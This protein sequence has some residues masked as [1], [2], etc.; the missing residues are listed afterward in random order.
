MIRR[1]RSQKPGLYLQVYPSPL[2]N[3]SRMEKI[4]TSLQAAR[5]VGETQLV[6][7]RS[8]DLPDS[9]TLAPGVSIQRLRG[10]TRPGAWGQVLRAVLWQPL[11]LA[12]YSRLQVS[13]VAA[14]NIWVLPMC[15]L[16]AKVKGAA[17]VYNCHELETEAATMTGI[18]QRVSKS[19]ERRIVG[20]CLIVSVVNE[21]IADWYE[22][23]YDIAR[24]VVIG[25]VPK[26]RDENANLRARLEINPGEMLYV[27]TGYLVEGR[28]IPLILS[29]FSASTH[30][31]VFLGE[32]PLREAVLAASVNHHNIHWLPPVDHDLI[33]AHVREADV[34]L[35]LIERQ[36]GLS[37]KLSSPNKLLES[38][39]AGT[40]PLC[41]DLVEARRLLGSLADKW[42]LTDPGAQLG[43]ALER[44]NKVDV[45]DF[46][47]EWRGATTWDDEVAPLLAAYSR[48]PVAHAPQSEPHHEKNE[49]S[50]S[51]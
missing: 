48:L 50:S 30:H 13:V 22:Q 6:G 25:N 21:S 51:G 31:V 19:F 3:A 7:V 10:T 45:D 12:H 44:I 46:K 18:K 1:R 4:A 32:G 11:V 26:V 42:I 9:E 8:S 33:V 35:C 43:A 27:H 41:S 29:A 5:A 40:P 39:T 20:H 36:L 47:S 28:N 15:W 17:L 49:A 23:E 38:L 2:V 14:H 37:D 34:G 24:P 16:L